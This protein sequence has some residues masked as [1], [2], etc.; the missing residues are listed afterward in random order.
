MHPVFYL[1]LLAG[2][3]CVAHY[4]GFDNNLVERDEPQEIESNLV[5]CPVCEDSSW[6]P[7]N[8]ACNIS[9]ENK[10]YKRCAY[11]VYINDVCGKR[12]D[13]YRF[14]PASYNGCSKMQENGKYCEYCGFVDDEYDEHSLLVHQQTPKHICNKILY[15]YKQK[16]KGFSRNGD[17]ILIFGRAESLPFDG[18]VVTKEPP[19]KSFI[20]PGIEVK[21]LGG[22]VGQYEMPLMFTFYRESDKKNFVFVREM[23]VS[24]QTYKT[25]KWSAKS[26]YSNS[27]WNH[28]EK[29]I[30]STDHVPFNSLYKIPP[31]L[32]KLLP[33]GLEE[34]ALEKIKETTEVKL[35]L[36]KVMIATRWYNPLIQSNE[37]QRSAV[38]HI[39]SKSSQRAP[40]MVS[41]MPP[42]LIPV[43]NGSDYANAYSVTNYAMSAYRIVMSHLFIDEAAQASE[44][45][46]LV[47]VCGLLARTGTLVL[48]GDPQQLGPVCISRDAKERGLGK[49]LMARLRSDYANLYESD[50]NYITMLVKNFRN[51]PD[52]LHLPNQLFYHGNLKGGESAVVFHSVNSREQRMGKA[53]SFF[54][55][56]ELDML[57]MYTKALVEKHDVKPVDIGI[58]APYIRQVYKMK[59]WL[60]SNAAAGLD[61]VEIGTVEAFQGKEKRVI[62]VSTVRANC[63]LLDYDAK[64]GLGFLVDDKAKLIIIGNPS[65]LGRDEKWRKYMAHCSDLKC[66]FGRE[67]EQLQRTSD[68]LT[69]VAINRNKQKENKMSENE[70]LRTGV[71]K[72]K[73]KEEVRQYLEEMGL[74]KKLHVIRWMGVVFL[75]IAFMMKI[76][77]YVNEPA[78]L[79]GLLKALH[80]LNDNFGNIYINLGAPLSVREYLNNAASDNTER[81]KPVDL[82]QL[83]QAQFQN[84]QD[85]ANYVI[86]LQQRNTVATISNLLAL[87]LMQS[88]MNG[89]A[90]ELNEVL[91]QVEWMVVVLRALGAS[92]FENDV[93]SSV[94]RVLVIHD[95]MMRLDRKNRL[96]LLSIEVVDVSVE[97]KKKMK[98]HILKA[99]TM[100]NAVPII[101]LQ[102]YVNPM[103]HYLVPPAVLA[104]I[105]TRA[106]LAREQ[107]N[108]ADSLEY[109]LQNKV[110]VT[111]G[112]TFVPGSDDKVSYLLKWA[113]W[114]ALST[115]LICA[116]VMAQNPRC[117]H[118]L[119]LQL[120]QEAG[121]ARRRHPYCLSMDAAGNCLAG[122]ALAGALVRDKS[123]QEQTY[124][125]VPPVLEQCRRLVSSVLPEFNVDFT[126][127]NPV[128]LDHKFASRL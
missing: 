69:E 52:I 14:P 1:A 65:C 114:P 3:S 38:Q 122:L 64:Y 68:L 51:A 84:V 41:V 34:D 128:I 66:Y 70:S 88:L 124:E 67:S 71:S 90:L 59:S 36:R 17:G 31:L 33:H 11:G 117:T 86:T 83:T 85:I 29:F 87:V 32:K 40:Y 37:E 121:E 126:A 42:E 103:L 12:R 62:L 53:P 81:L 118:K 50:P 20:K 27:D 107:L 108:F 94:A 82:Q 105:V 30:V 101:Q 78:V 5:E 49:S 26:P 43:S 75:K 13:C 106:P 45:A 98:G 113:V 77:I 16:K 104:V 2:G 92:V 28:A 19:T 63:R 119:A 46:A 35:Q 123:E 76:G 18:A 6:L 21:F 47:P 4:R 57:K 58:I 89:T 25:E 111:D 116:D 23:V 93:S 80:R 22:D 79:K 95:K 48:A 10:L 7:N 109:C 115:L 73:L 60:I 97:V 110:I 9:V 125:I 8:E 99:E 120:V 91:K 44:P 100:A 96:R 55:E 74:E 24:V 15:M 61:A 56:K 127:S 72:E 102:L 39:L 112:D 54:N